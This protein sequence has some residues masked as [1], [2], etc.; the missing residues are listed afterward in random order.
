MRTHARMAVLAVASA[1]AVLVVGLFLPI[2]IEW[3]VSGWCG[4][5]YSV[6]LWEGLAGLPAKSE[7]ERRD[8]LKENRTS[9]AVLL[10]LAAG[11]GSVVFLAGV[12]RVHPDAAKDYL[13]GP[14]GSLRDGRVQPST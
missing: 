10:A 13:E 2:W 4:V 14:N 1:I 11:T 8:S 9:C 6:P 7:K 3:R 5:G 12:R